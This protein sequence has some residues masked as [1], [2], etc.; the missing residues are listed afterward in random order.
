MNFN[1]RPN[2]GRTHGRGNSSSSNATGDSRPGIKRIPE[3]VL[4]AAGRSRVND[5]CEKR[6][7]LEDVTPQPGTTRIKEHLSPQIR[8][9]GER[10]ITIKRERQWPQRLN[11]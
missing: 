11:L 10:I 3:E 5:F 1:D 6:M 2:R 4:P 9:E 8:T 7:R